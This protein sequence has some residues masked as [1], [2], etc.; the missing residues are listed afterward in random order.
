[1]EMFR[2]VRVI[3]PETVVIEE[4]EKRE[5]EGAE[6]R[7]AVKSTAVCGSDIHIYRGLHPYC[8]LPTTI[9]HELSGVIDAVG[10]NAEGASVVD[11]VCVEPLMTCG[12]CWYCVRGRY[13]YCENLR[14]RYRSGYSGYA[15][16][17][18]SDARWIHKLPDN[19]SFDE[20]ALMEPLAGTVH[21]AIKTGIQ[22]ADSVCVVGDGAIG[23]MLAQLAV[24]SG[25]TR[26]FVLGLLSQNLEMAKRFGCVPMPSCQESIDEIL[27]LTQNRGVDVAFE[28]VGLPST[29][30]QTLKVVKRGGKAVIF[31]IFERDF[32]AW[33]LAAA[34]TREIE[35]IGSS[36]NCWDFQRAIDLVSSGRI[37]VKDLITHT[38]SLSNVSTALSLKLSPDQ[39]AIKIILKP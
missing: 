15:D 33:P 10:P 13:D 21:A 4:V 36:N 16:Y 22:L 23:L 31:G 19:V 32:S 5:P 24:A 3:A 18:Y 25:A 1:M 28:A 8:K 35:I 27:R 9:G 11:R 6:V 2:R 7:V 38:F 12:K 39:Q 14:L 20:G 30:E 34:M 26:V 29:F 17:Y 37:N